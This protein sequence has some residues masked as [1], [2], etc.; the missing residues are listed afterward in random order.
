[1]AMRKRH[2][3]QQVVRKLT[4]ADRMLAEGKQM[5]DVCCELQCAGCR[6][7]RWRLLWARRLRTMVV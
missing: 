2:S 5:A 4:Q 7:S 6:R 1:M 3:T